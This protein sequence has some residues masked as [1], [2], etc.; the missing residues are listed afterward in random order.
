MSKWIAFGV[1]AGIWLFGAG[2]LIGRQMP[3]H[4]FERFGTTGYLLDASTGRL[5][6]AF[7]ESKENPIDQAL[8]PKPNIFDQ[9][10]AGKSDTTGLGSAWTSP[11]P[12]IPPCTQ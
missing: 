10:T 12:K 8:A 6:L 7:P 5:C 4:R 3:A 2:L 11:S 9:A 1:L